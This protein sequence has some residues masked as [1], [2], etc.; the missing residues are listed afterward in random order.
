MLDGSIN[1][2]DKQAAG[3]A[4]PVWPVS[5]PDPA[6]VLAMNPIASP[7]R[8]ASF[9]VSGT[10]TSGTTPAMTVTV[11]APATAGAVSVTGTSWSAQISGMTEGVNNITVT[12][13]DLSGNVATMTAA[14][15]VHLPTGGFTPGAPVS[16][17]DA[18]KA[19]RMSVNLI[20]QPAAGSADLLHGDVAP[21]GAPDGRIDTADALLILKKAVGLVN[22]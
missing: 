8:L 12:A 19:L 1:G 13:G 10:I 16:V 6:P 15:T 4:S 17:I 20:P 2:L 11:T 21:L 5:G 9:N 7:T 22:F 3:N 14:V 18:L